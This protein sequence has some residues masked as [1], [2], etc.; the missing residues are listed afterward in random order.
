MHNLFFNEVPDLPG[1]IWLPIPNT[2][3]IYHCSNLGRIKRVHVT[4]QGLVK[5]QLLK[6]SVSS[7]GHLSISL[8]TSKR[9]RI[10]AYMSRIMLMTFS[11]HP[12]QDQL[13]VIHRD[14]NLL[15]VSLDNLSWETKSETIIHRNGC[16]G[17]RGRRRIKEKEYIKKNGKKAVKAVTVSDIQ[18]LQMFEMYSKGISQTQIAKHFNVSQP[19]VSRVLNHKLRTI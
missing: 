6:P 14:C 17:Y 2:L 16:T 9:Y 10:A 8:T 3:D 1:E 4:K 12:L 11:P 19:Y 5:T 18:I 15:N 13:E 7:A